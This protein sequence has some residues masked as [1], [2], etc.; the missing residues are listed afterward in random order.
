LRTTNWV[1]PEE[2]LM[3]KKD[4]VFDTLLDL[5]KVSKLKGEQIQKVITAQGA[6]NQST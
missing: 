1:I 3:G 2:S 4:S 6:A 5:A